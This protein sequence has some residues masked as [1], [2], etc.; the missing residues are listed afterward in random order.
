M[1]LHIPVPGTV[2]KEVVPPFKFLRTTGESSKQTL[3]IH[4]NK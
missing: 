3:T 4:H 1:L 2:K